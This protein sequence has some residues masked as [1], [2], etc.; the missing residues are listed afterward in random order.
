MNKSWMVLSIFLSLSIIATANERVIYGDDNRVDVVDSKNQTHVEL[1]LSTAAMISKSKISQKDDGY[2]ISTTTM[3]ERGYCESERFSKQPLAA[4]CSGF[5]VGPDLLVTA[6]HCIRSQSSCDS[7]SWVFNFKVDENGDVPAV[8][9]A[10]YVYNCAE[11]VERRLTSGDKDDYALIRL[12]R[13]VSVAEPLEYRASGSTEAG[14]KLVVIG[15]PTGLPTKIA[16]DAVNRDNSP[17][18]YFVANL[19]TYGGNSGSAV[20]NE[21]TGV[22]EGILVRGERDFVYDYANR[23][24]KSNVCSDDGCR[25]ED[26]TRITNIEA[27]KNI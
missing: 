24:Y 18:K 6:G 5:L 1:S 21:T 25:G 27:L 22:V 11:I 16:D 26:V 2:S 9:G 8:L 7:H 20:F 15:H 19:D 10:E 13:A 12:D 14:D 17:A 23:C 4:S 3:V